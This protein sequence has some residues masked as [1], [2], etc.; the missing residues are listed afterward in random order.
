MGDVVYS[1]S[2]VKQGVIDALV[3]ATGENTSFGTRV[4][5]GRRDADGQKRLQ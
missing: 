4:H 1:G 2:V 3:Y 5:L